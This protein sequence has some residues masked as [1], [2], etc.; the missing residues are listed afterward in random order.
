MWIVERMDFS[1]DPDDYRTL[2]MAGKVKNYGFMISTAS[3]SWECHKETKT[4]GSIN[5][6]F[7]CWNEIKTLRDQLTK[8]I[9]K[10]EHY[11]D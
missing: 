6:E 11:N 2:T 1:R 3:D 7:E 10:H 8:I 5:I 4:R 9:E